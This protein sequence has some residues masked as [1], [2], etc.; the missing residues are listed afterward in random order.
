MKDK[1]A[2]RHGDD[3]AT[4][5]CNSLCPQCV[6]GR[7]ESVDRVEERLESMGISKLHSVMAVV[8]AQKKNNAFCK[9]GTLDE[10]SLEEMEHYRENMS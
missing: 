10:L 2:E 9:A 1:W 8:L 4:A 5:H 3:S 7:W 6:A